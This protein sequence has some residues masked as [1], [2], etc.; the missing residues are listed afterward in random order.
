MKNVKYSVEVQ[1]YGNPINVREHPQSEILGVFDSR[2][3]A[4]RF[5]QEGRFPDR[6]AEDIG[7]WI[8][9]EG[10]RTYLYKVKM[11]PM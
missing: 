6:Y 9:A 7:G 4:E 3:E 10:P 2:G 5:V 1:E 11:V 8:T